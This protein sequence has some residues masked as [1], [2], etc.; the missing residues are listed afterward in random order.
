MSEP[1]SAILRRQNDQSMHLLLRAM[2]AS[3]ERAQRLDAVSAIV[4]IAVATSGYV[5]TFVAAAAVPITAVGALWALAYSIGVASWTDTELRRAATI[6]EMF[7]V[8]LFG[9]GWNHVLAGEPVEAAD[10][11]RLSS[12]YRGREDMIRD[13]YE[14][15]DFPAPYD[16]LACQM[17][18]LGWGARVRLRFAYA[19]LSI[20]L[21]WVSAGAVIGA[22]TDI[23]VSQLFLALYVPSLGGLMLG[24]DMA[25]RQRN[26]VRERQRVLTH[27]RSAVAVTVGPAADTSTETWLLP[28][29]RQVQDAIFLT[30]VC[31]PRVPTWFFLRF[32]TTDRV[33][34]VA[35]MQDL[36][37]RLIE[38]GSQP[39]A[40]TAAPTKGI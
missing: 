17:M 35:D 8:R 23:T 31:C 37:S 36:Q 7:D 34:F 12:R 13:Y 21:V 1:V 18:N 5:A 11:S 4:S 6:Q 24:L 39:S 16:I 26:V 20:L 19:I 25:R 40:A 2:S 27:L 15:P 22:I 10:V 29:A 3:H 32:R 28:L 30:R 33:D 9:L 38:R 14:V